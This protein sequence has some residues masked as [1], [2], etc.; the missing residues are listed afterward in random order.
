MALIVEY[1]GTGY[2]GFQM[3]AGEPTIQGEIERA[4]KKL[5]GERIRI[6][7]AGRTDAG[8]HARGQMVSFSCPSK[9][10]LETVIRALNFH[11]PSDIAVK[12]GS[13]VDKSFSAR[14]D[15]LSREYR[16]T[17]LNSATPSPLQRKYAYHVT[18]PLDIDA[19]NEACRFLPG[20][21]DF[22]SFTGPMGEKRTVRRVSKAEV[23]REREMV[24]LDMVA[25]SFLYKQVRSTAGCLVRV[26]LGKLTTEE[27]KGILEA[28]KPGL[29]APVAPAQGLCLM[30]VNY[31]EHKL[32]KGQF[33]EN[34]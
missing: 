15:A 33:Y 11:L 13:E 28:K 22:A 5:T 17:I 25:D 3:Q 30:K 31:P 29:A 1:D 4:L 23:L 32:S 18:L 7:G 20:T 2:H 16:Y 27:F 26:G 24:F 6:V 9:L 8:V 34:S 21:W 12:A 14:R 10:S 19:M